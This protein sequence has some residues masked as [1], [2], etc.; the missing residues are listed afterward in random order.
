MATKISHE[1]IGTGQTVDTGTVDLVTTTIPDNSTVHIEA[2]GLALSTV[3]DGGGHSDQAFYKRVGGG[4]VIIG[5]VSPDVHV[6]DAAITTS[7]I[8]FVISVNDVIVRAS[9]TTGKTINWMASVHI[10]TW[11]P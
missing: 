2:C 10:H 5:S 9:G 6:V 1:V 7:D 4:A 11:T 8:T 3:G